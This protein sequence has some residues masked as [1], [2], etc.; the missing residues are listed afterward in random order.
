MRSCVARGPASVGVIASSTVAIAHT[1]DARPGIGAH[2]TAVTTLTYSPDRR[3]VVS[4]GDNNEVIVWDPSTAT[5]AEVLTAPAEQVQGVAFSP[6]GAT[7]YTS[8]TLKRTAALASVK[9]R[10]S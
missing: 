10:V 3:A 8:N 5:S 2:G 4:T 7:L 6:D 9:H 1:G